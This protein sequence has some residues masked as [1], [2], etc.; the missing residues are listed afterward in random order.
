MMSAAEQYMRDQKPVQLLSPTQA[1]TIA[2]DFGLDFLSK[3][4]SRIRQIVMACLRAGSATL[5]FVGAASSATY[6]ATKQVATGAANVVLAPFELIGKMKDAMAKSPV[7][8]DKK[9]EDPPPGSTTNKSNVALDESF[10]APT[11]PTDPMALAAEVAKNGLGLEM[12]GL[13]DELAAVYANLTAYLEPLMNG[14]AALLARTP[15]EAVVV[16]RALGDEAERLCYAQNLSARQIAAVSKQ[17]VDT[18][19]KYKGRAPESVVYLIQR[20]RENPQTVAAIGEGSNE[21]RLIAILEAHE[22]VSLGY[23]NHVATVSSLLMSHHDEPETAARIK[24]T[25]LEASAA[26]QKELKVGEDVIQSGITAGNRPMLAPLTGEQST[27]YGATPV[28]DLLEARMPKPADAEKNQAQSA[29]A[30]AQGSDGQ[31]TPPV[32]TASMLSQPAPKSKDDTPLA[33]KSEQEQSAARVAAQTIA[34]AS[35]ET[36]FNASLGRTTKVGPTKSGFGS[37]TQSSPALQPDE[38]D[39]SGED[40]DENNRGLIR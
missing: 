24:A 1:S 25:F 12:T 21:A 35:G 18:D 5:G 4:I 9:K 15:E 38:S 3:L 7:D 39:V 27:L 6:K 20:L 23:M 34:T 2:T 17:M 11:K 40:D 10:L 31:G 19:P 28:A 16:A 33:D 30:G 14:R 22:K 29:L 13:P 8:P 26:T 37:S 32:T 36:A